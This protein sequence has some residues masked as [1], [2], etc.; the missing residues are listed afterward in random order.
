[1]QHDLNS[2]APV[3][4]ATAN[5]SNKSRSADLLDQIYNRRHV[6]NQEP[7]AS[8]TSTMD[9]PNASNTFKPNVSTIQKGSE[10]DVKYVGENWIEAQKQN[11]RFPLSVVHLRFYYILTGLGHSQWK[12]HVAVRF[13]KTTTVTWESFSQSIEPEGHCDNFFIAGFCRNFFED[14]HPRKSKK[15]FFYPKVGHS[16]MAYNS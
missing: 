5:G 4:E 11:V 3:T 14:C 2:N 8:I 1:M 15:H 16:L 10:P 12:D 7:H 9:D 13:S 6:F